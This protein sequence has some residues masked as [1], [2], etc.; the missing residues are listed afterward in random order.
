MDNIVDQLQK[1]LDVAKAAHALT[2]LATTRDG[3]IIVGPQGWEHLMKTVRALKD[4]S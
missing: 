3:N 4:Q 2:L 1:L